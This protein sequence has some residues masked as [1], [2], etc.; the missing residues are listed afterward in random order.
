MKKYG[1]LAVSSPASGST[2]A[3]SGKDPVAMVG[4]VGF[5]A[6]QTE[7]T[8]PHGLGLLPGP[9]LALANAD[10]A[11]AAGLANPQDWGTIEVRMGQSTTDLK[12][13][14]FWEYVGSP[15]TPVGAGTYSSENVYIEVKDG[16]PVG[17][18]DLIAY[19]G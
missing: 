16:T 10:P 19:W 14:L 6:A 3:V 8:L 13:S 5:N 1:V 2:V 7:F 4:R 11:Y 15:G 12:P 18:T 9:N 17:W